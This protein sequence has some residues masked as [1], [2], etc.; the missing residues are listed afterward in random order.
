MHPAASRGALL[1]VVQA[2]PDGHRDK[3][4]RPGPGFRCWRLGRRLPAALVR[5]RPVAGGDVH[6]AHPPQVARAADED[7]VQA[8]PAHA[9]PETRADGLCPQRG[10]ACAGS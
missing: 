5:A 1:R 6:P 7:L 9:A 10:V 3:P 4:A 2:T 8:R